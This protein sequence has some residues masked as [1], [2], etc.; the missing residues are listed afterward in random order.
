MAS[1]LVLDMDEEADPQ[2]LLVTL[3]PMRLEISVRRRYERVE[4][5]PISPP[6]SQRPRKIKQR[7]FLRLET[8]VIST[9]RG[10]IPRKRK[11]WQRKKG[12]EK[13]QRKEERRACD[14][15]VR[16]AGTLGLPLRP[17]PTEI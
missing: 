8:S 1:D 12:K 5:S 17:Y 9:G 13:E 15:S 10:Q 2:G 6:Y 4:S 3:R 16:E 14:V 11:G 7:K